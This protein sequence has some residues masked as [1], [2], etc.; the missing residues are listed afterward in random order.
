MLYTKGW[1]TI[2]SE[3]T[4]ECNVVTIFRQIYHRESYPNSYYDQQY[5]NCALTIFESAIKVEI[6]LHKAGFSGST[7]LPRAINSF[8]VTSV[9][10]SREILYKN[11]EGIEAVLW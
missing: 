8:A 7:K 10:S 9:G 5:I 1:W 11:R 2:H 3:M 4:F 6:F